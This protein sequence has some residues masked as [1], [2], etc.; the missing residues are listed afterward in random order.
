MDKVEIILRTGQEGEDV[1]MEQLVCWSISKV[2]APLL[3]F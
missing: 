2:L 3:T 1:I